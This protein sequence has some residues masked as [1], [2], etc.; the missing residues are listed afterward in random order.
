L[1]TSPRRFAFFSAAIV[2]CFSAL[3]WAV[4]DWSG[5]RLETHA[6]GV[7]PFA[8]FFLAGIG[9]VWHVRKHPAQERGPVRLVR[10]RTLELDSE[11][12]AETA[13]NEILEMLVSN[14]PLDAVLDATVRLIQAQIPDADC[15]ILLRR[16]RAE[17]LSVTPGFPREWLTALSIPYA[18]PFEVWRSQRLHREIAANPAWKVFNAQLYR[19]SPRAI[20]SLPIGGPS[21]TLGAL[22]LCYREGKEPSEQ[23]PEFAA[24]GL[25]LARIAMEHNRIYH[26]LHFEAHHDSLTGLPNRALFEERLETSLLEAA[27]MG[28]KLAVLFIDM[29][30]FKQINDSFSHRFGDRFLCEIAAR[31]KKAMRPGDIIARIGGDEFTV[32]ADGIAGIGEAEAICE[33]ILHAVRQPMVIDGREVA[34]SAS[35]GIAAYPE[36]GNN[37]EQLLQH[38][39]AA[40][41]SAKDCGRSSI[42]PFATRDGGIDRFR[43][44][45][46]LKLA[47]END[48]FVVHYQ[49]KVGVDGTLA[50][51]EALVRMKH[52]EYGPIPPASFISVAEA[53]GLIVPLGAWVL[54]EACRQ[55]ADWKARGLGRIPIAVN[56]SPVQ[57]S[58][59]GFAAMVEECLARHGVPPASIELELTES[60]LLGGAHEPK[61]QMRALRSLGVRFSIDDFGTGYSSL[62]YLHRLQVD[63]IKLDK[64]FVQSIDTDELAYR[65]V[66]A[67]IGVA[68]GLGLTVVAEGVETQEQRASL[69][70]AGC[71]YM[72]GYLFAHPL[73][74]DE[75]ETLLRRPMLPHGDLMNLDLSLRELT[76]VAVE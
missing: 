73:P 14:E 12:L 8:V 66:K 54:E 57:I 49:P 30:G 63:A 75:I 4:L 58:R 55:S 6:G 67:M 38:A 59:T 69:I 43:M 32:L 34:A 50:G 27:V 71:P 48:G 41:Y 29:D 25:R 40:M 11:R 20:H 52:S 46:Q 7:G 74:A 26:N 65:L 64:S 13:R 60:L 3:A 68:Q 44:N 61:E 36:D 70:A 16:P 28:R 9:V 53:N 62:S 35:I 23:D 21:S 72:Q 37:A 39:D 22:L 18:V 31:M 1:E 42:Q 5:F 33:R 24:P 15:A 17:R 56:V 45:E 10:P 2:L 51:L 47:I 76:A 19:P